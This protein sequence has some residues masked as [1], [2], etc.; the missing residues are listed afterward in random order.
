MTKAVN[1]K[2]KAGLLSAAIVIAGFV[3]VAQ[4]Q[5]AAQTKACAIGARVQV[6]MIDGAV[7]TITEIGTESPHV[8]WYRIVYDWNVRAGNPQGEW[9]SPKNREI[10]VEGTNTKC[11][12]ANAATQST[13]Q[14]KT[15][16]T[17]APKQNGTNASLEE[18]EC[19]MNQ[20]SG[21]VTKTSTASTQLFQRVIYEKMAAKV[22]EKSISA[23]KQIGLTFMEFE[24]GKVYKNTLTR[25]GIGDQRLHDGAPVGAMIYPVKTKYVKCE[26]YDRSIT[27]WVIQ[28]NFACFKDRFGDWV[29]PTD[30]VPKFLEQKSIPI[31]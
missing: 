10:R 27:R 14:E 24:M 16:N 9:Y 7:G 11:G 15:N 2:Q 4:T 3:L 8:G 5:V 31:K 26:L 22:N 29:C 19:P 30:S 20:P 1:L 28:Q 21:K 17:T 12:L 6:E 23:P 25:G 18:D 13:S